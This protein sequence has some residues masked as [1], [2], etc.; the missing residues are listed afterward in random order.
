VI[1]YFSSNIGGGARKYE[2]PFIVAG[3][4]SRLFSF[5]YHKNCTGMELYFAGHCN[6]QPVVEAITQKRLL[7]YAMVKNGI[8]NMNLF[9]A[10]GENKSWLKAIEEAGGEKFLY[11]YFYLNKG[12]NNNPADFL[13]WSFQSQKK[14]FIDS[15]GF[16]A[17]TK[18]ITIDIGEYCDW[19]LQYKSKFEVYANLDAIGDPV[20][21]KLNQEYME[22]RGLN[23]LPV[24]HYK[25][26]YSVLEEMCSRYNYLA[27]GALVPIARSK[28]ELRRHLDKCFSLT[29]NKVKV[30]GFGMTGRI[31]LKEYPFYSVDSTSWLGGSMR[32]EI[33]RFTGSDMEFIDTNS[34]KESSAENFAFTDQNDKRWMPRVIN[35]AI[36]WMKYEKYITDLW[37]KRGVIWND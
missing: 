8:T 5:F 19:L 1:I 25:T 6:N 30:H 17:F 24:F 36:E 37:A 2:L 28:P 26:S 22:A 29:G 35:N 31:I 12:N 33:Y 18:G 7:S 20:K 10:G 3:L 27:L 23:P 9:F 11:S 4:R 13:L 16:S 14:I 15:G 32:A 21:T 34:K